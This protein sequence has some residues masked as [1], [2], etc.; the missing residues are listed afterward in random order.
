MENQ[1]TK[2]IAEQIKISSFFVVAALSPSF[3][4]SLACVILYLFSAFPEVKEP[5]SNYLKNL[6]SRQTEEE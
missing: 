6:F 5:V 3:L 4:I 2:T 1:D